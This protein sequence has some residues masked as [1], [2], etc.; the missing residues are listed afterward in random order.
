MTLLRQLF[1]GQGQLEICVD[2]LTHGVNHAAHLPRSHNGRDNIT[3]PND[4]NQKK[5]QY[6]LAVFRFIR[7]VHPQFIHQ[8]VKQSLNIIL[9]MGIVGNAELLLRIGKGEGQ[10]VDSQNN[11]RKKLCE[12]YR[13]C[14]AEYAYLFDEERGGWFYKKINSRDFKPLTL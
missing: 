6:I 3:V 13:D 12:F 8:H 11:V 4:L 10:P 2:I 9:Y 5:T 14:W 1:Q 7:L